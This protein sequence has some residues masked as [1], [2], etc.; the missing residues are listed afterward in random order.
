MEVTVLGSGTVEPS[1]LRAS[2]GYLVTFEGGGSPLGVDLGAGAL[3]TA[4][5]AGLP[6]HR[7]ERLALTHLHPDHT[8]DLVPL[9]FARKCAP[10]PWGEAAPLTLLGPPG[11]SRMLEGMFEAWP[12]LRPEG[13]RSPLSVVELDPAGGQHR[14]ESDTLLFWFPVEHGDQSAYAYRVER[15]AAERTESTVFSG[16]TALCAGVKAAARQADLFFCELSCY[17][18]GCEPL[19]CREVHLSWEDVVEI[20]SEARVKRLLL[21]HLYQRVL[22]AEPSPL[23]SVRRALDIPVDLAADGRTY[24]LTSSGQ[25]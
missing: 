2:S 4:I 1:A 19:R 12:S 7:V 17:P 16:D 6:M 9:L 14:L 5:A 11:T 15:R 23:Q 20:C 10:S 13:E 22:E 8:A 24:R 18:R 3:R 25:P 21:T